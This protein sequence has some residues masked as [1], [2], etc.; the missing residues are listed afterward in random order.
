ME[1]NFSE[2]Q[3][4]IL[5]RFLLETIT[6]QQIEGSESAISGFAYH[7]ERLHVPNALSA[8]VHQVCIYLHGA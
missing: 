5:K 7:R 1:I 6:L 8:V 2:L 3:A 4:R